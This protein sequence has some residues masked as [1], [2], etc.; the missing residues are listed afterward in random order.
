MVNSSLDQLMQAAS[1]DGSLVLVGSS[2]NR[3]ISR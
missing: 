1:K 2:L 3:G